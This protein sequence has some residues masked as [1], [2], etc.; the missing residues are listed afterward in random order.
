MV[1]FEMVM[2]NEFSDRVPQRIFTKENHAF[3][4]TFFNC[5]DEPFRMRVQIRRARE[6]EFAT[7]ATRTT[8][9]A[10]ISASFHNLT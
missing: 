2:G 6:C 10:P 4:A 7:V 3:E 9:E 5:A 8:Y 1:P